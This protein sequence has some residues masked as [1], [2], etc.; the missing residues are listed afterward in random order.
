[1]QA[2]REFYEFLLIFLREKLFRQTPSDLQVQKCEYLSPRQLS[3]TTNFCMIH[4]GFNICYNTFAAVMSYSHDFLVI[5][6]QSI[7]KKGHNFVKSF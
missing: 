2:K 4:T 3:Y 5:Y 1:M 6:L 7:L